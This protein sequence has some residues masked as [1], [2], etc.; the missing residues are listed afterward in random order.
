MR[1]AVAHIVQAETGFYVVCRHA[2]AERRR[3]ESKATPV[4]DAVR[5]AVRRNFARGASQ[6]KIMV[7]GGISSLKGGL[8]FAQFTDEEA[9][10]VRE[11]R[12]ILEFDE[13]IVAPRNGFA[14]AA[15][16]YAACH[17]RQFLGAIRVPTLV[18][19]DHDDEEIPHADAEA[20]AAA[21]PGATLVSTRGLGHHRIVRDEAVIERAVAFV[22]NGTAE[23]AVA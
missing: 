20:V 7:G 14:N 13:K 4:P 21:A 10:H 15:A 6:I 9:R 5:A 8:A 16:Y 19:H 17:A 2:L 11:A 18:V 1:D 3:G 22:A 12:S 23:R